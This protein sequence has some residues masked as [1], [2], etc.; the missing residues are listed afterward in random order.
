M[1]VVSDCGTGADGPNIEL[2]DAWTSRALGTTSSTAASSPRTP[3]TLIDMTVSGS[4]HDR[5]TWDQ[6]PRL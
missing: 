2:E 5:P 6:P 4:S 3:P 1:G